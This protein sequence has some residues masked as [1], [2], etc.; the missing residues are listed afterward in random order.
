M[1]VTHSH[2][3]PVPDELNVDGSVLSEPRVVI[4]RDGHVPLEFGEAAGAALLAF[5]N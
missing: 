5:R 2:E 1:A 3:G 4:A